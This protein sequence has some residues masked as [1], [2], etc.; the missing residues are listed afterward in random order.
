M[1]MSVSLLIVLLLIFIS[2]AGVKL[3]NL[4]S[5]FGIV[6]P[7]LAFATLLIG[8]T[9]RIVKWGKS[10]VPFRIP[11]TG[12]QLRS[13]PW[14]KYSKLDNPSTTLGVVGRMALEI[15]LFRSL[16]RNTKSDLV[17]NKLVHG[18]SKWLWLFGLMF[19]W[20]FFIILIRHMRLFLEEV[21]PYV[22]FLESIDGF[23]QIGTPRLMMTGL[24]IIAGV[25]LLFLRR[26]YNPQVRYISLISDYFPLFLI[27]AIASS[28]VIMRYFL[29]TDIVGVK[30]FLMGLVNLKPEVPEN[31]NVVFYI[32]I[33]LVSVLMAYFPFSK[34]MHLGGIFLSPTRNLANNSRVKR[35]I[36]PWDYPV[37]VHAYEEYEEEFRKKMKDAGIPVEK[38]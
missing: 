24:L 15:L 16:F 29:K 17:G 38:E 22:H 1:R 37:K 4:E 14:I 12:G 5:I 18:S 23:F 32:H 10:A 20:S 6:I 21:P 31:I 13:M 28:G 2:Y 3:A 11:T 36:N 19:H 26:L 7:Y 35:H 9:Y 30:N 34:L 25:T 27:L 8:F 33:F